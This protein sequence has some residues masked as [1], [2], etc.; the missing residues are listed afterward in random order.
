MQARSTQFVEDLV[1]RGLREPFQGQTQ[2]FFTV[3]SERKKGQILLTEK[4]NKLVV[5]I[6][7]VKLDTD[8]LFEELELEGA[9]AK[10]GQ[11]ALKNTRRTIIFG[12]IYGVGG[13]L[14]E[15]RP[16]TNLSPTIRGLSAAERSL[17]EAR[18]EV[19]G[20]GGQESSVSAMKA[21][22]RGV[23]RFDVGTFGTLETSIVS[24]LFWN[25]AQRLVTRPMFAPVFTRDALGE[26]NCAGARSTFAPGMDEELILKLLL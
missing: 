25:F 2:D 16:D 12:D 7:V 3:R 26:S 13:G 22:E 17:V 19:V 1:A 24:A 15:I 6:L 8:S 11:L 10:L 5:G 4:L 20:R 18:R 9:P 14:I 23:K 21:C